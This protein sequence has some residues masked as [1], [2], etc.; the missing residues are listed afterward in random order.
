MRVAAAATALTLLA[1][2][3]SA[4]AARG[5]SDYVRAVYVDSL[6]VRPV[7]LQLWLESEATNREL[8]ACIGGHREGDAF[9]ITRAADLR[10]L[11]AGSAPAKPARNARDTAY[12]SDSVS[13]SRHFSEVSV[14]TCRPPEWV[15][16]VHTHRMED[17]VEYPK[18]SSNDRAVISLWH[19]RWRRESVFCVLFS[20]EKPPYCEYQPGA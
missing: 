8:V 16:T 17:G 14:H 19:E 1:L 7:L 6:R 12:E 18:L 5:Q 2:A 15:G 20:P 11:L 9:R 3:G 10:A 4:A 13:V